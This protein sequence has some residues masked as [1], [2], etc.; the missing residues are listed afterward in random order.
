MLL[1]LL[2]FACSSQSEAPS[3]SDPAAR[4]ATH[5][6]EAGQTSAQLK[7]VSETIAVEA[8][9]NLDAL[10]DVESKVS[11]L[12]LKEEV[13]EVRKLVESLQNQIEQ[14]A[15]ELRIEKE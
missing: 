14:A 7:D 10:P 13:A 9:K 3:A 12:F 4:S 2:L 8:R 15:K 11:P 6:M 5:I 1:H